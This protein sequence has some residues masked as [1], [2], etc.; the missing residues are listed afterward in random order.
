MSELRA[1]FVKTL[2]ATDASESNTHQAGLLIP[3][4]TAVNSDIFPEIDIEADVRDEP[5]EV[6]SGTDGSAH[7]L[8]F[9]YYDSKD[10]YRLVWIQNLLARLGGASAG[11]TFTLELT[12]DARVTAYVREPNRAWLVIASGDDRQYGGNEGYADEPAS[13]YVWDSTVPHH[14]DLQVGDRI[15]IWDKR[16]LVGFSV[17]EDVHMERS[18]KILRRCPAC[19]KSRFKERK[20]LSPTYRCQACGQ[21]FDAPDTATTPVTVYRSRHDAAWVDARGALSGEE[22]R[23]LCGSPRA[24]HSIRPLAWN[25][26]VA[27]IAD[28]GFEVEVDNVDRRARSAHGGHRVT[29]ARVRTG[30]GR[31]RRQLLERYGP[32]CAFMGVLPESV[33]EAAHLYRFAEVGSHLDLGGLMLRR[34]VHRL[35]D[36]GEI[37]INPETLAIDVRPE[38]LDYPVYASIHGFHVRV[39]LDERQVEWL[40]DHW[41]QHRE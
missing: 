39:N 10:E 5:M 4:S 17:V 23:R 36:L 34:D 31:F 18:T 32:V 13:M 28:E 7:V 40:R 20:T 15:A 25:R 1:R 3:K 6:F 9:V 2:S 29:M 30:Q 33:L 16:E 26:F 38:L 35:F 14:R 12:A 19:A 24:Q 27:S 21:E 11:D 37:A 8:R 41:R 22:L